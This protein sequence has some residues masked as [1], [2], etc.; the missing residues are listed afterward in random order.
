M[1]ALALLL[2]SSLS[3]CMS[4]GLAPCNGTPQSATSITDLQCWSGKGDKQAQFALGQI[5]ESGAGV[6]INLKRARSFYASAA[7][8]TPSTIYVYSPPVG[9]ESYGRVI[10]MT[11]G[12][13]APGLAEAHVALARV[14]AKLNDIARE[15]APQKQ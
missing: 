13:A 11:S 1:K 5:Y 10:P 7:S 8:A 3:G 9:N 4:L 12:I 6:P 2:C 14:T 15:T